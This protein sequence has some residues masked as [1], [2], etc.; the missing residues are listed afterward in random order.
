MMLLGKS[1][2]AMTPLRPSGTADIDGKILD[3]TSDGEFI[4]SKSPIEVIRIEGNK[5]VVKP[6][7]AEDA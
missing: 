4:D 3:V 6:M 7:D 1:G 5:F 2:T